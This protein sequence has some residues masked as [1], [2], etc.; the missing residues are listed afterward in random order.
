[1]AD[2]AEGG[3]I[4][5][6]VTLRRALP[7]AGEETFRTRGKFTALLQSQQFIRGITTITGM[8]ETDKMDTDFHSGG[9]EK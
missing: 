5:P 8:C 2:L 7:G 4:A 9:T 3:E 6:P 1:M